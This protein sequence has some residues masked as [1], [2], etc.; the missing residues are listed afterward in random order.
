MGRRTLLQRLLGL[1]CALSAPVMLHSAPL[2]VKNVILSY[3]QE[4]M[5]TPQEK[6]YLHTDRTSYSAGERIWFRAYLVSAVTHREEEAYSNFVNVELVNRKDSVLLSKKVKGIERNFRGELLLSPELPAGDYYLRAYTNWMQNEDPDFFFMRLIKIGNA[7]DH[8]F[9]TTATYEN[10]GNN[11][12]STALQIKN[13]NDPTYNR[14]DVNYQVYEGDVRLKQGKIKTDG[15]G[16]AKIEVPFKNGSKLPQRIELQLDDD[17]YDY[18][19]TLYPAVK[20]TEYAVTFFPEGGD[21]LAAPN[22][23]VAFKAQAA[24]G[25]ALPVSGVVKNAAG[26]QVAE[27]ETLCDGMG[28]F[29]LSAAAG[30]SFYAET[31][32]P[33]GTKKRFDLPEVKA[34]GIKI[35]AKRVRAGIA[36]ELLKASDTAWPDTLYVAAHVRGLLRYVQ[37]MG[38]ERTTDI[39]PE[40]YLRDGIAHLLLLNKAGETLSERLVFVKRP[41]QPILKATV[42]KPI[43]TQRDRARIALSLNDYDGTPLTGDLSVSITDKMLAPVDSMADHILSNLLLTS[44]LKGFVENPGRY[45]LPS[46]RRAAMEQNL[47]MLTHGWRRFRTDHLAQRPDTTFQ[48]YVESG[49]SFTGRVRPVLGSAAGLN[50][51]AMAASSNIMLSAITD[52]K[53][54]FVIQGRDYPDSTKFTLRSM[55]RGDLQATVIPDPVEQFPAQNRK[56]PYPDHRPSTALT[57]DALEAARNKY[58]AEGGMPIT[59]LKE[60]VITQKREE[61]K[62]GD[63]NYVYSR[64]ADRRFGS[65][66]FE[67]KEGMSAWE[68]MMQIPN[69]TQVDIEGNEALAFTGRPD[70][71]PL[72]IINDIPYDRPEDYSL[73]KGYSASEIVRVDFIQ[74]SVAAKQ[75]LGA[76]GANGAIV[77]T[78]QS[79][80]K[81]EARGNAKGIV[82]MPRGYNT[83]IEYYHPVYLNPTQKENPEPDLRTTLYWNPEVPIREDG[84]ALFEFFTDDRSNPLQLRVEGITTDGRPVILLQDIPRK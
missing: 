38:A 27:I 1:L 7:I 11:T 13:M 61:V 2:D 76:Q 80:D 20:S 9:Q 42:E 44:D 74:F 39:I 25:Y 75:M 69:L 12:I 19:T 18:S 28:A 64:M 81:L 10:L 43:Y 52:K 4:L 41:Q 72:L 23:I 15:A 6:V 14:Y 57:E 84:S 82:F 46:N 22:Q 73:L 37:I 16:R 40:D 21:L 35:T 45:F 34:Q 24:D 59:N 36:Y 55:G 65:E 53:G 83:S 3:F 77:V 58:Y 49:L 5:K 66:F 8:N 47:L 50:V 71:A 79:T 26:E 17:R 54:T 70:V 48:Y 31:T 67:D 68:A 51:V 78:I 63:P 32:S 62:A 60:I 56:L 30:D 29:N 33:D